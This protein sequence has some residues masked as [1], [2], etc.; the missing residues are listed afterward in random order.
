MDTGT[1]RLLYLATAMD[2]FK[3]LGKPHG[4][5][6]FNIHSFIC[7]SSACALGL[8]GLVP[9]FIADGLKMTVRRER[10]SD[11]GPIVKFEF[12][13][14]YGDDAIAEFFGITVKDVD[15]LFYPQN[16]DAQDEHEMAASIRTFVADS[17]HL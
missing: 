2:N 16:N 17:A 8:A 15:D 11:N 7:G 3:E 6:E 12:Q 9:Q 14:S 1:A 4:I 13:D 10:F 5:D